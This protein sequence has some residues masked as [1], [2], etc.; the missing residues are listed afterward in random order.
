V[1]VSRRRSSHHCVYV[2]LVVCCSP[3]YQV[4][5]V[6]L[7]S[8]LERLISRDLNT[9]RR[10][11]IGCSNIFL[12]SGTGGMISGMIGIYIVGH[13]S[14][15]ATISGHD[16]RRSQHQSPPPVSWISW[17]SRSASNGLTSARALWAA[18]LEIDQLSAGRLLPLA[19]GCVSQPSGLFVLCRNE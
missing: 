7:G 1:C 9:S 14:L 10:R 12:R 8:Q 11:L 13:P 3:S 17:I 19:A 16:R 5:G 6:T 18:R 15:S 2:P 4:P